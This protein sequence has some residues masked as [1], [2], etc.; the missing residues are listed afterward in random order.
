MSREENID[1]AGQLLASL[2]E[3]KEPG[4]IAALFRED[5]VFEIPGDAAALPWIGRKTG[6]EAV[7]GFIR[8]LRVMTEPVK[9]DVQDILASDTRAA[10]IGEL[11][12]RIKATGEVVESP[13]AIILTI[14][15]GEIAHFQMLENSF[16]VSRAARV[17]IAVSSG[18]RSPGA[19]RSPVGEDLPD[20]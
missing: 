14:S 12:T 1:I 2:G 4:V 7:A 6:R 17:S 5:V 9:F 18:A 20:R 10:I 3:G 8:G 15:G 11:A 19:T 16:A 13:F